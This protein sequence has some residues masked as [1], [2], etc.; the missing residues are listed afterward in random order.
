M[1]Q[2]AEGSP[3]W[4]RAH[5]RA[6]AE[7]ARALDSI[8]QAAAAIT[9]MVRDWSTLDDELK[10]ALLHSA[11]IHYARPFSFKPDYGGKRLRRH[12]SYDGDLHRHLLELRNGFIAHHLHETLRAQVG[13]GY[14]ELKLSGTSTRALVTTHCVV[15][16]LYGIEDRTVA[17]RYTRHL[18]A[19]VE[20]LRELAVERLAAVHRMALRFPENAEADM[21]TAASSQLPVEQSVFQTRIPNV[22]EMGAAGIPNPGFPLPPDAYKYRVAAMTHP[23]TGRYEIKTPVGTAV[24]ALSDRPFQEP[25]QIE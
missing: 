18:N 11:A 17:E 14:C 15:K 13:H 7:Y 22:L 9:R 2:V 19:C 3:E 25:I 24:I 10:S 8:E 1:A 20:C 5:R 4:F 6:T 12:P 21:D 16:A 23:R